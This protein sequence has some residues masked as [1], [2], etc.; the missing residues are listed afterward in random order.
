MNKRL[1]LSATAAACAATAVLPPAPAWAWGRLG[2]RVSGR[3]AAGLLTPRAAAAVRAILEPGETLSDASTWAD[4]NRRSHPEANSWHYVNVSIDEPSYDDRFCPARGCVVS[5][6]E[7]FRKVVVDPAAS[8]AKKRLALRF[9]IHFVED[10]HQPLHVGDRGDRGGNS[11]QVQFFNRGTNLHAVWD[12]GLLEHVSKSEEVWF[13][14]VDNE[15]RSDAAQGWR[16][17]DVRAWAEES[18]AAAKV[19]YQVPDGGGEL[20]R[21]GVRLGDAYEDANVAT[22][23]KRVAQSAVRLAALLNDLFDR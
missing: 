7:E 21:S 23:Q 17:L 15:A 11:T 18:H 19:A 1:I 12:Y 20:I 16:T 13:K 10:V 5:K 22:A 14:K 3:V 4:E 2:H 6:I 8:P 9:L